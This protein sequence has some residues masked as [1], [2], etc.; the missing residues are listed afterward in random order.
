MTTKPDKTV[1]PGIDWMVR[2]IVEQFH[3]RQIILFGSHAR[4]TAANDSDVDL[5]VV[6]D[7]KGSKRQ[8]ATQIDLALADRDLPLDLL[9]VTPEEVSKYKDVVGHILYPVTR[10][11]KVLYDSAA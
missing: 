10:E 9:V 4:G 2:R 8:L 3:P 11:G 7:V 1:V 5:L 6:M